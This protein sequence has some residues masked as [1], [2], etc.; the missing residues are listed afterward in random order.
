MFKKII[1]LTIPTFLFFFLL[2]ELLFNIIIPASELP[3][4]V[5]DNKYKLIKF[6]ENQSG[7]YSIG[8]FPEEKFRWEINNE[9][10]NNKKDYYQNKTKYR[11]AIIGDSYVE[12]FQ[13][14]VNESFPSLLQLKFPKL[15]F[16]SFGISGSPLSNYY[17]MIKYISKKFNPDFYVIN[18]VGND[19]DESLHSLRKRDVFTTLK[20][21]ES[22]VFITP[23][24]SSQKRL[25]N[26]LNYSSTF[27]YFY[28]NL[29]FFHKIKNVI[30]EKNSRRN[31]LL[32]DQNFRG[33]I[34]A[35]ISIIIDS[36]STITKNNLL[37]VVDGNRHKI[38]NNENRG[39]ENFYKKDFIS[40]LKN[41]SIKFID[42]DTTFSANYNQYSIKFNSDLDYHWNSYGHAIVAKEINNF[43]NEKVLK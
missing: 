36:I 41:R 11:I 31:F 42:L 10:W 33:K 15:E 7:Y 27:R 6:N 25:I 34:K 37:F 30:L 29:A 4:V 2:L 39:K 14:N 18:V 40:I 5:F 26:I 8:K 3:D 24:G 38:Y 12:A 9:G 20:I 28:H 16:Y 1:L 22:P 17:Q 19:Y 32:G 43:L 23:N 21:G 35:G 13:V